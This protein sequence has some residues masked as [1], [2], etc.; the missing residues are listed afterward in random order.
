MRI[1]TDIL[2]L[3]SAV[4]IEAQVAPQAP[5]E[6]QRLDITYTLGADSSLTELR[7]GEM[8][9]RDSPLAEPFHNLIIPRRN[10]AGSMKVDRLELVRG[11]TATPLSRTPE[12]S[13][14][15]FVWTAAD[16]V[17]GDVIRFTV[18]QPVDPTA[19]TSDGWWFS[20][21]TI[22]P[23]PVRQGM[24]HVATPAN[25]TGTVAAIDK[26]APGTSD[27]WLLNS[28]SAAD[29]AARFTLSSFHTWEALAGWAA[30]NRAAS[31][32]PRIEEM[33]GR[34]RAASGDPQVRLES[35]VHEVEE[36]IS[37]R[38]GVAEM[39]LACRP[40][41]TV[42]ESGS[43]SVPETQAVL[44]AVI[45]SLGLPVERLLTGD[46]LASTK[47]PNPDSFGGALL[48]VDTPGGTRWIDVK[49]MERGA[50]GL[51][52]D[53]A[54]QTGLPIR[55]T[56]SA[57][58]QPLAEE[59]S[60]TLEASKLS[61]QLDVSFSSTG[62]M[63]ASVDASASGAAA[64]RF[65][66]GPNGEQPFGP[67]LKDLPLRSA[68]IHGDPERSIEAKFDAGNDSF[69]APYDHRKRSPFSVMRLA[70]DLVTL[71]D[72]SLLLGAPGTYKETVH[73]EIPPDRIAPGYGRMNFRRDAAEYHS[74][75]KVENGSLVIT[76]ELDIRSAIVS[77]QDAT[78]IKTIWRA[79]QVSQ[80]QSF[81]L[82]HNAPENWEAIATATP[83]YQ[84]LQAGFQILRQQAEPEGARIFFQHAVD[85]KQ[86]Q[87]EY[88]LAMALEQLDRYQDAEQAYEAEIHDD[89]SF[90]PPYIALENLLWREGD[91]A[92][93]ID[94]YKQRLAAAPADV[95]AQMGIV[96]VYL[97]AGKTQEAEAAASRL[98]L[99]PPLDRGIKFDTVVAGVCQGKGGRAE[100]DALLSPGS[101]ALGLLG[102]PEILLAC[103][104][105]VNL[106]D[107]LLTA[108]TNDPSHYDVERANDLRDAFAAENIRAL[109]LESRG[110]LA[111]RKG[112]HTA[113][114]AYL[115]AAAETG[116]N[117]EM[118]IRFAQALWDSGVQDAAAK[119][120]A[121]QVWAD[122]LATQAVQLESIPEEARA[123]LP[124]P[125]IVD[126][127]WY[128]IAPANADLFEDFEPRYYYVWGKEDGS[129]DRVRQ[130][131]PEPS[132]PEAMTEL[133]KL[134]LPRVVVEGKGI[135]TVSIVMLKP[136]PEG[137]AGFYRSDSEQT[138]LQMT[139][140]SPENFPVL[141]AVSAAVAARQA[142][143]DQQQ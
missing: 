19:K 101:T 51:S 107:G 18:E 22:V 121:L 71:P 117:P 8:I 30:R 62:A 94:V 126:R 125:R 27:A 99:A 92:K 133:R 15:Y 42:L 79:M 85:A 134:V 73:V 106:I 84:L 17:P 110:R 65:A 60:V 78:N 120:E 23:L 74:E 57:W 2:C 4:C 119:E 68:S 105:D 114:L 1:V 135:P 113:G 72:G 53:M 12:T 143:I 100:L 108:L 31:S 36:R 130:L 38:S 61:L 69:F 75:T 86:P 70:P 132:T 44:A 39:S 97:Y 10:A 29:H 76:R 102:V 116:E 47:L 20:N 88:Y 7:T 49:H 131:S 128:K 40:V 81:G 21:T 87:A 6:Y 52:V 83:Q 127:A 142:A 3:M 123:K 111:L 32:G 58:T 64:R 103:S 9:L 35:A 93:E 13:G 41:S 63:Y 91:F 140:L 82:T 48:R 16:A 124:P 43:A 26:T 89:P 25:F 67:F 59:P 50:G 138:F 136:G 11:S 139:E 45:Q 34:A 14:D 77:S 129:I 28:S 5:A 118:R 95:A 56:G 112:D 137:I 109:I 90:A 24:V 66:A 37:L 122:L 96:A 115:R 80:D 104:G 98:R 55:E 33:A 46:A 54:A 141:P